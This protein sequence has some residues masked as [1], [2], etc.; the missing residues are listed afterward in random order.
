[1]VAELLPLLSW[2]ERPLRF[3]PGTTVVYDVWVP[4]VTCVS[5]WSPSIHAAV[6]GRE[7]DADGALAMRAALTIGNVERTSANALIPRTTCRLPPPMTPPAGCAPALRH[8]TSAV[9][10]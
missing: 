7:A 4:P 10:I 8:R 9:A 5:P 3:P 6:V 1:M 2:N